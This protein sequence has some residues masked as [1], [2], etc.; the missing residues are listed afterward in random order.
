M[1]CNR[2]LF[3]TQEFSFFHLEFL[4][5]EGEF[6]FL[7]FQLGLHELEFVGGFGLHKLLLGLHFLHA[8]LALDLFHLNFGHLRGVRRRRLGRR[9]GFDRFDN[10]HHRKTE[11]EALAHGH[12]KGFDRFYPRRAKGHEGL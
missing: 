10:I 6:L 5:L 8:H 7:H 9:R 2:D 11:F 1:L 3:L 4:G 12:E